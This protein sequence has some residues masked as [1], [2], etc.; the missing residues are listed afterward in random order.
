MQEKSCGTVLF[1]MKD[2]KILYLLTQ[3]PH[4]GY[5][6]FPKGHME[7]EETEEQTAY[8]ETWEE[9][10]I[11]ASID[12]AFRE[13]TRYMLKNGNLK[14]VVYFLGEYSEQ[15]PKHNEGFERL[16][17]LLLPFEEAHRA[18]TFDNAKDILTRADAY[19]HKKLQDSI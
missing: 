15:T 12:T 2:G 4:D 9:T 6:G 8:R 16:N 10:S 13:E 7:G 14:L 1:T 17:Y 5:C 3:A 11:R 18:L 19:I